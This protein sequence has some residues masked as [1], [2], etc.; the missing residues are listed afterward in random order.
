MRIIYKIVLALPHFAE[1]LWLKHEMLILLCINN[2]CWLRVP[3]P[4]TLIPG[5]SSLQ[6]KRLRACYLRKLISEDNYLPNEKVIKKLLF[7]LSIQTWL[8]LTK[9]QA[10]QFWVDWWCYLTIVFCI[11]TTN[12]YLWLPTMH[13]ERHFLT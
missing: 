12:H 5:L 6:C 2:S 7:K 8:L 13:S 1:H 11:H 9:L 10:R 4:R 3:L